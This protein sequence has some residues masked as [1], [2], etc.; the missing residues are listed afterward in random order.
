MKKRQI[1]ILLLI[2]GFLLATLGVA[3]VAQEERQPGERERIQRRERGEQGPVRR[4]FSSV[5]R[6]FSSEDMA[7]R[8][9]SS[10]KESLGSTDEEWKVLE[11]KLK[12]LVEARF[13][14]RRLS[15][16]QLGS[17]Q[18]FSAGR[19]FG[20]A[21]Q[22]VEATPQ[23]QLMNLLQDESASADAIRAKLA[24]LRSQREK[25]RKENE[26]KIQQLQTQIAKQETEL[27]ALLTVRQEA[28]LVLRGVIS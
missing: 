5:R 6:R 23:S 11:P 3:A 16:A 2:A 28:L 27:K 4:L 12:A 8:Y 18:G 26:K 19:R 25:E 1:Y 24:E 9:V 21:Q 15:T 13:E 7:E 22:E 10:L 17:M 20:S 14:L